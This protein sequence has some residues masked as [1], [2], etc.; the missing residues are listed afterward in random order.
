MRVCRGSYWNQFTFTSWTLAAL[1]NRLWSIHPDRSNLLEQAPGNN[2]PEETT[3]QLDIQPLSQLRCF[4]FSSNAR[5]WNINVNL[6]INISSDLRARKLKRSSFIANIYFMLLW[7]TIYIFFQ[8]LQFGAWTHHNLES[9][10]LLGPSGPCGQ[11]IVSID[12]RQRSSCR[13]Q[14]MCCSQWS[15]DRDRPLGSINGDLS[16]VCS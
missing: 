10:L 13:I 8:F 12:R 1:C 11:H 16:I 5:V 9:V 4:N 14:Q 2:I 3:W 7:Q 15:S 6:F